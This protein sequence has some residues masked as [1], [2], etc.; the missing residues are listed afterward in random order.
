MYYLH[1]QSYIRLSKK[2]H[3]GKGFLALKLDMS[4]VYDHAEWPFLHQMLL[5]MCFASSW[6]DF[7]MHCIGS[8]SYSIVVNECECEK[9]KPKRGLR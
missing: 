4:K 3:R 5:K 2:E 8:V 6:V 1:M 9:F 7:I